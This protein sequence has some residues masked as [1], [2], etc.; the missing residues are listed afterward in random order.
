VSIA[1]RDGRRTLAEELRLQ[2][3]DEI[4]RGALEP[5]A[6]LDEMEL[7][8]AFAC[9]APRCARRSGSSPHRA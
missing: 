7:R 5:G 3:A 9:R 4:V 2:L 1:L 8:A 6:A